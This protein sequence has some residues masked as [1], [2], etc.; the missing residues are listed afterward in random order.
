VVN[1]WHL[2]QAVAND[3]EGDDLCAVAPVARGDAHHHADGAA[4]REPLPV[5]RRVAVHR[6][7][8]DGEP[9]RLGATRFLLLRY[10]AGLDPQ[11]QVTEWPGW[12]KAPAD[13]KARFE[14]P[15]GAGEPRALIEYRYA[16]GPGVLAGDAASTFF[17]FLADQLWLR[18]KVPDGF[19]VDV[20]PRPAVASTTS[21]ASGTA[22]SG[23]GGF[24]SGG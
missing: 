9:T 7:C 13:V 11:V 3:G 4:P 2:A 19:P 12:E 8:L 21:S 1:R 16:E 20:P 14:A 24:R 15:N 5:V 22:S 17:G 6:H 10:D 18:G 23:S